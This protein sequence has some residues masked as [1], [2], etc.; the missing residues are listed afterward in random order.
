VPPRLLVVPRLII[1]STMVQSAILTASAA[2]QQDEP[3]PGRAVAGANRLPRR[4]MD[5]RCLSL[6]W[7]VPRETLSDSIVS[8]VCEVTERGDLTGP[9]SLRWPWTLSRRT[10]VYGPTPETSE[11]V[12]QFLP[13]TIVEDELV[14]FAAEGD[15][16]QPVWH[17]RSDTE[18]EFIRAPQ[19]LPLGTAKGFIH[20]RCLNGTGGCMDYPYQFRRDNSV[21]ALVMRYVDQIQ[22][23]LPTDWS[24]RKGIWL[25]PNQTE[26]ETVVYLPG[27]ANCCPSFQASSRLELTGDTLYT[28]SIVIS[29]E[30]QADTW[31]IQPSERFGPIDPR[32]SEHD[33]MRRI[34][35]SALKQAE[36][37]IAEG[38]CTAGTQL[39]SGTP[40]ELDIAWLDTT[41][42]QPAFVR[43]RKSDGP[44]H[45]PLG[46]RVGTTLA[47]LERLAGAPITFG[48]FGWDYGGGAGWEEGGGQLGLRLSIAAESNDLLLEL[49]KRDERTRQLFGERPVRSDH[50]VVRQLRIVVEEM[51]L[52]WGAHG[53]EHECY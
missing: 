35:Q 52:G 14:I 39:F 11:S 41:R 38:I 8:E 51:S 48:G 49:S 53:D 18:Y 29:P 6:S 20:R 32:T 19:S 13:D 12:R 25:R 26:A 42:T 36:I 16:V 34:G 30:I 47:E 2:A 31:L 21:R 22:H 3:P 23:Q 9:D 17:D 40:A 28:D 33:L 24:I 4:A 43:V 7:D 46:V 5:G 1:C 10:L 15:T 37:Y 27:D 50:P 44:W 45:T